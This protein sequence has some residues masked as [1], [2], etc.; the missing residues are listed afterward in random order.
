MTTLNKDL[1]K[2]NQDYT[3]SVLSIKNNL[4]YFL[5]TFVY[6]DVYYHTF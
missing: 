1:L 4:M 2:G 3:V 5:N 6:T